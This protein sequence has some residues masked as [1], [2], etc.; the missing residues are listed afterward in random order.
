MS[1]RIPLILGAGQFGAANTDERVSDPAVAQ[2]LVDLM[3]SHGCTSI[4]TSPFYCNGTSEKPGDHS[5]EKVKKS[6]EASVK[7]L[8]GKK[9]RVYYLN[10]P[11]RSFP[12]EDT[13]EAINDIYNAGG[14]EVFGLANYMAF[15][16]AEVVS[17]CKR[18][19]F[20][21]PTVY[22]GVY[23]L[24]DRLTEN[25]LFPCLRKFNIKFAGYTP[26]AGGYLTERFFVPDASKDVP[27]S[28]FDPARSS[29]SW[30]H[31]GR[32]YP[33]ASAV[34]ELKDI[35]HAHGL[36]LTEVALRWLQWHSKLQPDDYGVIVA[37]SAKEQLQTILEDS[38]KGPLPDAVVEACEDT[39]KKARGAITKYWF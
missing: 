21:M 30:F 20:V 37:A 31:T 17:I 28:K 19:G 15:E 32:Y 12:F 2:E 23:N 27:L 3:V 38:V 18:R 26:L 11:D 39:W 9:I 10:V 14:F 33:S 29:F 34:A 8:N 36:T 16:V 24:I 13:L 35:A 25:E 5:P 6:F 1:T 22:Q 7:A 4:E